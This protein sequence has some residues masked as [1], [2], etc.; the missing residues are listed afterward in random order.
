MAVLHE[1][2]DGKTAGRLMGRHGSCLAGQCI[3]SVVLHTAKYVATFDSCLT[4]W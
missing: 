3:F 2:T 4:V 1:S